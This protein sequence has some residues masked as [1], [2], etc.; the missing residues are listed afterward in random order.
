MSR[1]VKFAVSIY[2][3]VVAVLCCSYLIMILIGTFQGNDM[4]GAVLDADN[5]KNIE[6]LNK[7]NNTNDSQKPT[8]S[9]T[10]RI[11]NDTQS[12]NTKNKSIQYEK[13]TH[14]WPVDDTISTSHV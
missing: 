2:L 14:T 10:S 9:E 12:F 5:N 8:T 3:T 4:R 6:S 13:L 11:P 1:S 7:D